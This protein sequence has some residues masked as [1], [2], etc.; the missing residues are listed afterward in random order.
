MKKRIL[1]FLQRFYLDQLFSQIWQNLREAAYR[2]WWNYKRGFGR[3]DQQLIKTYM[4]E[5]SVRKLQIGA[6]TN[7]LPGWLNTNYFPWERNVLHLD[8][9]K[10]FPFEDQSFDYIFSEHMIEHIT[11]TQGLQMLKECHRILKPNG[12]IRLSTPDFQFLIDLYIQEHND[13][14]A[15]YTK[16]M[17]NYMREQEPDSAPVDTPIFV[18]NNFVRDWGHLFIYDEDSLRLSME[19]VGFT[20]ISRCALLE[21]ED[22]ALQNLENENRYPEGFLRL[23]TITMDAEKL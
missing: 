23:E 8:A 6:G 1:A 10:T 9:T 22:L 15:R 14:Q 2:I 11:Y 12:K 17:A 19:K 21:S 16:W 13:L 5:H 4:H 18:I 3:T 7:L 20:T